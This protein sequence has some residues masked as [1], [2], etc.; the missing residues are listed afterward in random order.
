MSINSQ[1]LSLEETIDM[2]KQKQS[3]LISKKQKY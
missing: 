1:I 2:Y 3:N